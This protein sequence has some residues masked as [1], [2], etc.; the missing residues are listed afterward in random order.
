MRAELIEEG[1]IT[2][3]TAALAV[4]LEKGRCL[5]QNFSQLEQKEIKDKFKK[6]AN[7]PNGKLVK[8]MV[9]H[10]EIMLAII[11]SSAGSASV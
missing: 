3:E 9:D 8:D 7:S 1:E 6:M 11:S 4:L 10:I 2:E 5:K